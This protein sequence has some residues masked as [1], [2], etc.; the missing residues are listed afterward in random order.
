MHEILF[1]IIFP[2]QFGDEDGIQMTV[3]E[4]NGP[5]DILITTQQKYKRLDYK[6]SLTVLCSFGILVRDE[7]PSANLRF[8]TESCWLRW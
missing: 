8:T 5:A 4:L 2:Q 7:P 6:V 1:L 3:P